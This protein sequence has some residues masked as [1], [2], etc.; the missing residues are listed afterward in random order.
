MRA[1]LKLLAAV[2]FLGAVGSAQ[3]AP[4]ADAG[5][6]V[7]GLGFQS[8]YYDGDVGVDW[9]S[10]RPTFFEAEV[11]ADTANPNGLN[12]GVTLRAEGIVMWRTAPHWR[13]GGGIHFTELF[14]SAY[15]K[16]YVWPTLGAMF[17]K[18]WF[19]LNA[20]CLIPVSPDGLVGPLFDARMH[21]R[22]NFYF[23]ERV[24]I[25]WYVNSTDANPSR[26]ASGVAD[27]GVLYVFRGCGENCR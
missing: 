5:I 14:T 12:N 3:M 11:G 17:E 21:L 9:G 24:G 8:P 1:L 27:F 6:G 4:Y 18:N 15:G 26:H 2:L 7:N 20:Q 13:L 19:R 23:R 22:K 16:E 10:L 25:Y